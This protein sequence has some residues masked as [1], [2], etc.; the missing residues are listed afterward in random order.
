MARRSKKKPPRRTRGPQHRINDRIRA[1]EVRLV[2]HP[3]ESKNGVMPTRQALDL[4][5][6]QEQDLVEIAPNAEPPVCRI[7]EYSRFLYEQKKKQKE[8]KAKQHQVQVKEIRFG[9][10]TDDHDFNFKLRYARKFIEDGDKVRSYIQFR[11][12]S[13]VHK[14][15]GREILDRF[16]EELSDVAKVEME[17]K[18]E[19]KRMFIILS[20][21]K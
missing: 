10:N 16:I 20:P 17:P 8:A 13:I 19:G 4:A 11:G 7:V 12:R 2:G 9:P 6:E 5:Q 1:P 21:K 15:R 14:E 18:M 3:D